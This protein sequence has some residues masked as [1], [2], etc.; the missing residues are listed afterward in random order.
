MWFSDNCLV[1]TIFVLW[2]L[3]NVGLFTQGIRYVRLGLFPLDNEGPKLAEVLTYIGRGFGR[4]LLLNCS[5]VVTPMTRAL[6]HALRR[7]WLNVLMPFD[8]ATRAHKTLGYAITVG[9]IGHATCLFSVYFLRW[10]N[11]EM[12]AGGIFGLKTT[13]VTGI[14]LV[15]TLTVKLP[16]THLALMS[17][18]DTFAATL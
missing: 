15:A 3:L 6:V 10:S 11:E 1:A 7:T 9:A 5:L 12:W 2:V 4:T 17:P 13:F 14:S 18:P 16:L 8:D